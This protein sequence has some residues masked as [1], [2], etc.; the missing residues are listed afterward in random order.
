AVREQIFRRF[1]QGDERRRGNA[2]WH[3]PRGGGGHARADARLRGR[4]R[5]GVARRVRSGQADGCGR[6]RGERGVARAA[7]RARSRGPRL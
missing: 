6:A 5:H 7:G 2:R 3:G 4:A 1:R